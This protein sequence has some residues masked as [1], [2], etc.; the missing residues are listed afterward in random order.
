MEVLQKEEGYLMELEQNEKILNHKQ[1]EF[2]KYET[3]SISQPKNDII[4]TLNSQYYLIKKIG[5]GASGTVFLSYAINDEK[6]QKTFYAIKILNPKNSNENNINSCE[7]NFLE[8]MNH[9][10]ILKVYGHGLGI[11]QLISG[12]TQK[13]HYI[14][15]DY[16]NHGSLLSQLGKN[17]GF[18]EDLGRLIFA[19]LLDG[20][21]AIHNSNIVHLDI[22]LNNIMTSEDDYTLKYVDF[23]FATEISSGYLT[24]YLGT[25]NYAAPEL[26]M[27]IPYL[28]VYEDIFSL[29]VTIFIIVTGYLPFLLPLPND[30]LYHYI[31]I[32]DY[33]TFWKKRNIKVSPS[34]MELFNNLVAF[35]PIQRPSISEIK[36][37]KWMKE[38]NWDLLP[39]LKQEF[40][41]REEIINNRIKDA[42]NKM[43]QLT[44][45]INNNNTTNVNEII[46][47]IKE[48]K[49]IEI[50]N[51]IKKKLP[52]ITGTKE[53]N[54][55]KNASNNIKKN[56]NNDNK[57]F[58]IEKNVGFIFIKNNCN[59]IKGLMILL[60]NFFKKEGYSE[61]KKD[62][63][64]LQMEISNGEIDIVLIFERMNKEIKT[65]YLS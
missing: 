40:M 58:R 14:I 9:K 60:K 13:V 22:K 42:K 3:K 28:G 32:G 16:L 27:R 35:D 39:L 29:G 30:P 24:L 63:D 46:L 10:N 18:G 38:I 6:E 8:N 15:M 21:E 50:E 64:N 62:L 7:V 52:N 49:K 37:S 45:K 34:F 4:G 48:E 17:V 33:I 25:P 65:S 56:E 36:K 5:H 12:S 1:T 47:K 59:S 11:L 44:N 43:I 51:D 61:T 26:H 57:I 41:K 53:K 31:S 23:G 55:N 20:L 54:L 2:Q 19:Q